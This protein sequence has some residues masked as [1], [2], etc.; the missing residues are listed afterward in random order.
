MSR[1]FLTL[2]EAASYVR[3]TPEELRQYVNNGKVSAVKVGVGLV[4]DVHSL[5]RMM[6]DLARQLPV[7]TVQKQIEEERRRRAELPAED[8]KD[9]LSVSAELRAD[10]KA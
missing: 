6:R 4:F 3:M 5:Q 9:G 2:D 7:G 1:R 8:V 10:S